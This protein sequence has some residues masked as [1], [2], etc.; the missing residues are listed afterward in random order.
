MEKR[1][2]RKGE[3]FC[4]DLTD[5]EEAG[6]I[7]LGVLDLWRDRERCKILVSEAGVET[8]L[9]P[10]LFGSFGIF[11]GRVLSLWPSN[12]GGVGGQN[13]REFLP[14]ILALK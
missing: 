5:K 14:R 12:G 1:R 3:C 6:M 13:W 8:L 2:R 11:P 7:L 10:F 4:T 9:N